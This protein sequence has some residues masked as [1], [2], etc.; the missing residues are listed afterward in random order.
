M[1]VLKIT[2]ALGLV[3]FLT[4]LAA[5]QQTGSATSQADKMCMPTSLV[6]RYVY[7]R[8]TEPPLNQSLTEAEERPFPWRHVLAAA[9]SVRA[10]RT[11]QADVSGPSQS[12]R[13][14]SKNVKYSCLVDFLFHKL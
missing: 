5:A 7:S 14:F 1:L 6:G 4:S 8:M 12:L 13:K 11:R 2:I 3:A 10:S 9:M